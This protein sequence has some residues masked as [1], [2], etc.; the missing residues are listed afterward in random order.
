MTLTVTDNGSATD[1]VT[2]SVTVAPVATGIKFVGAANAG[3]GNVKTKTVTVP[4]GAHAGDTALLWLTQATAATWSGPAG[5]TGWTKVGSYANGTL[6]TTLWEKSLA[7]GDVGHPVTFTSATASHASADVAVYSGV[8]AT[9]P[10]AGF[11]EYLDHR[12]DLAHG[13]GD[14]RRRR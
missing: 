12:P 13:A 9:T 4:A 1:T 14:H 11:T 10:V 5:V 8:D 2:K 6:G 7:S 3:G